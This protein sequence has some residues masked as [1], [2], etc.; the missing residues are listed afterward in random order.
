MSIL[1]LL[2]SK[3]SLEDVHDFS[4]SLDPVQLSQ[5]EQIDMDC[6]HLHLEPQ[7]AIEGTAK[8]STSC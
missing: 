4:Y 8:V 6:K 2:N 5:T 1:I 3:E 7:L